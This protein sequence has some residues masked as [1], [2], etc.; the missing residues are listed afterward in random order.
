MVFTKV[1]ARMHNFLGTVAQLTRNKGRVLF[2]AVFLE[3]YLSSDRP[4]TG[5]LFLNHHNRLEAMIP[6]HQNARHQ[7]LG[8][9]N[10]GH[11]IRGKE[12]ATNRR[13]KHLEQPA[14]VW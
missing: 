12:R 13:P 8:H 7:N 5:P 14:G 9:Q 6:Q 3:D 1:T 4:L 2:Y 11:E 10:T